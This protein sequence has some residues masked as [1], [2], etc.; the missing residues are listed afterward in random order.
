MSE[1]DI[2][3]PGI[4]MLSDFKI[5]INYIK[6][7]VLNI[8]QTFSKVGD[9]SYLLMPFNGNLKSILYGWTFKF[10]SYP[11][12]SMPMCSYSSK[13]GNPST[14]SY[15]FINYFFIF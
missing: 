3:F 9:I 1:W 15:S 8:L 10:S 7:N 11:A 4:M 13:I 14:I 12:L 2:F 6:Y 5:T